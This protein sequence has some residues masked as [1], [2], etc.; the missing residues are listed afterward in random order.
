MFRG[1]FYGFE[2]RSRLFEKG[3][4][5]LCYS[6]PFE[7]SKPAHG[8]EIIRALEE[9]CPRILFAECRKRLSNAATA[10]GFGLL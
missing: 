6:R 10:G 7:E 4:L 2:R 8:Y 1:R 9:R 5:K 3:D